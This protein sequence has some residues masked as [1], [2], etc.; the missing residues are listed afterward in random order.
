[1]KKTIIIFLL[2]YTSLFASAQIQK[3]ILGVTLGQTTRA[4]TQNLYPNAKGNWAGDIEIALFPGSDLNSSIVEGEAALNIDSPKFAGLE[5]RYAHFSFYQ[6]VLSEVHFSSKDSKDGSTESD[7][8]E[9]CNALTKKYGTY[10]K[11]HHEAIGERDISYEI[12][13][14]GKT[15]IIT[16]LYSTFYVLEYQHVSLF[17]KK[18][19]NKLDP[20]EL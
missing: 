10:K 9:L 8:E 5:W 3:T 7:W 16:C 17:N 11:T 6:G 19:Q 15:R 13:S 14:D 18:Y 20:S 4:Q 2:A 12:Y 1:M